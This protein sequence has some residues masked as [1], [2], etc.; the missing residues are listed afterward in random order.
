MST[1]QHAPDGKKPPGG[2]VVRLVERTTE[3][4]RDVWHL[5][6]GG[7][8]I[9]VTGADGTITRYTPKAGDVLAWL[10]AAELPGP[11]ADHGELLFGRSRMG[12]VL[13]AATPELFRALQAALAAWRAA[14]HRTTV[15]LLPPSSEHARAPRERPAEFAPPSVTLLSDQLTQ[16]AIRGMWAPHEWQRP[17]DGLPYFVDASGVQVYAAPPATGGTPSPEAIAAAS[18]IVLD[19]DDNKVSAFIICLGK[20]FAE[21][22]TAAAQLE[23]ARLHVEDVL[24]FRGL[25]KHAHGGYRPEQKEEAKHDILFL[26]NLWVRSREVVWDVNKRGKREKVAVAVDDPLIEVSIESTVDLWGNE[27]PFAFRVRPGPWAKHYLGEGT[28]WTTSVL[29][30]IMR[31]HPYS[32]RLKMRL[33]IYLAFQWRIRARIGTWDQPWK[34]RTLLEGAKIE[35]PKKDPQRFFPRVLASLQEMQRDGV[36][37]VCEALDYPNW[38]PPADEP[39]KRWVP[40]L[41]EGRW[42]LL[43]PDAVRDRLPASGGATRLPG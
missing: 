10:P 11:L 18:R 42:R 35:I 20:W 12:R 37:A 28:H 31:Y 25:K 34:L 23:P 9:T 17:A 2:P 4:G 1:Q 27:T 22:G 8:E 36:L 7:A 6:M 26:R 16:A 32:D 21:T 41:L 39:P 3:Q 38:Q 33:G 43:P 40:K 29:R 19:L 30:Q 5:E 15:V 13:T 24:A 14:G